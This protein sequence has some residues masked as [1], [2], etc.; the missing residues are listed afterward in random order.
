MTPI[1]EKRKHDE[2]LT[3]ESF[4]RKML[5]RPELAA[6]GG[7]VIVFAIFALISIS[8]KKTGFLTVSGV[9]SYL[10][11]ASEIGILGIAVSLL[12]IGGEFDLSIGSIL[13][14]SGM[15]TAILSAQ[16]GWNIWSAILVSLFVSLAIGAINGFLVIRTRLPSF[17]VTLGTMFIFRGLTIAYTR[18][19]TGRTQVG[20]LKNVLGFDSASPFFASKINIAGSDFAIS[21]VWWLVIAAAATYFLLRTRPGNWI[22]GIGG[23]QNASRNVGVPVDRMKIILFMLTATAAW[24]VG[25]I[26]VLYTGSADTLRGQ[27][28]EFYAII[29]AVI[30]GT[31]LTGGYGSAV[32]A[33]F[34]ALIYGMV[35][36]GIVYVGIDA[37]WF[38]VVLGAM[39]VGAVLVNNFIRRRVS[40]EGK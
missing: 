8:L 23:D 35:Q 15:I 14:A 39:L 17:I 4:T 10:Q 29:V 20:G 25:T 1:A 36:Q 38:Q 32:G 33:L 18:Q 27:G 28:R 5:R 37:D 13:G 40:A 6:I 12:M 19:I 31:L 22:F 16:Y 11:V 2:R 21:I 9:A 34:G 30:G 24:L 26:Q 3:Q 7:A